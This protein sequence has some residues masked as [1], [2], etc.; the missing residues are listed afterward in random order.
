MITNVLPPFLWFTVYKRTQSPG[1]L[2]SSES[3]ELLGAVHQMNWVDCRNDFDI[4][5]A[6]STRC[7]HT[8]HLFAYY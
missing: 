6:A 8:T 3:G 7:T 2:A 5:V 1:R 4:R